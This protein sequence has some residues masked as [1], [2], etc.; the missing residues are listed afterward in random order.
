MRCMIFNISAFLFDCF[1]SS[2]CIV[3][4][5]NDV[6]DVQALIAPLLDWFV[7]RDVRNLCFL[8]SHV[9]SATYLLPEIP[10]EKTH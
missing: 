4:R 5:H 7:E 2:P 1:K 8:K 10:A 9:T 3:P 6:E